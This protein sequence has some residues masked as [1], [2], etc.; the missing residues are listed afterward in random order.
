MKWPF[1]RQDPCPS[2]DAVAA[3]AEAS[4]ALRDARALTSRANRIGDRITRTARRNGFGAAVV[5]TFR[6]A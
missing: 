6:G 3:D 5:D 4:R 1:R 2:L